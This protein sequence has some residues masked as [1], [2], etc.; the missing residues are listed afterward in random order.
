MNTTPFTTDQLE[1]AFDNLGLYDMDIRPDYSGRGMYGDTCFGIVHSDSESMVALAIVDALFTVDEMTLAGPAEVLM[2]AQQILRTT[3]N[4]SM[5]RSA[6]TYFPG[7][8][9][10]DTNEDNDN[11]TED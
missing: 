3:R 8:Q 5:G 6:I 7:W 2:Q 10:P 1:I 4:D 11:E 9:L